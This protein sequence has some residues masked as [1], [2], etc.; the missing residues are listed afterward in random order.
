MD[1]Y[2]PKAIIRAWNTRMI[3]RFQ[4]LWIAVATA[5]E[6]YMLDVTDFSN[7]T[8]LHAFLRD[9]LELHHPGDSPLAEALHKNFSTL[10]SSYDYNSN[11]DA[12]L[13]IAIS[14]PA[15]S[16]LYAYQAAAVDAGLNST[17][18]DVQDSDTGLSPRHFISLAELLQSQLPLD[19]N[20]EYVA[21]HEHALKF[22]ENENN[23]DKFLRLLSQH[24]PDS[25]STTN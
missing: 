11:C 6:T 5:N 21:C 18:L 1:H 10:T 9:M 16:A 24:N 19:R 15:L 8:E 20:P 13:H 4:N 17:D 14:R 25:H 3:R 7:M 12:N 2:I 22:S 23:R